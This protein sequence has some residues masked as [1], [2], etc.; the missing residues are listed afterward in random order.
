MADQANDSN[1]ANPSQR[2]PLDSFRMVAETQ[3]QVAEATDRALELVK[4]HYKKPEDLAACIEKEGTPVYIIAGPFLTKLVLFVLGFEPGFI[5]PGNSRRHRWL[6]QLLDQVQAKPGCHR[7]HG[8]FVM[9]RSVFTVGFLA[10]QLHHWMACRAGLPGYGETEQGLYKKF[11]EQD[12]GIVTPKRAEQMSAEEIIQLRNA[13]HR[14]M[15]ALRF[16]QQ[17]VQELFAPANQA[18]NLSQGNAT[19]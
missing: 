19:A 3:K 2:S 12:H 15:E 14:D 4:Q 9:T 5:P 7:E 13:I 6:Y 8:V 17:L 1:T 16:M 11:W 18:A 10:H